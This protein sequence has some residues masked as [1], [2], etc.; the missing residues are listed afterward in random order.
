[1]RYLLD[2]S[3][4]LWGLWSLEKMN[5]GA[6]Q[7]LTGGSKE[8]YLSAAS[9]WEI[10]IKSASG[11]LNLPGPPGRYVTDRVTLLG[12]QSL[13]ITQAHALGVSELPL[14]HQDPFDRILIAQARTEKMVLMTTD[15]ALSKY[16]V[17]TFWCAK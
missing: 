6:R 12:L 4:F 15:H 1:M 7:I 3:V 13:P 14:H 17:Q 9:A 5:E 16:Q 11:K 2:T 8:L 10:A